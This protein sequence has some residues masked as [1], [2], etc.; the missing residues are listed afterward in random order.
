MDNNLIKEKK[1][2][3]ILIII[4][5]ILGLIVIFSLIF[6][7]E[8]IDTK[9][10]K[11][12]FIQIDNTR[13]ENISSGL[14]NQV[15]LSSMA[16]EKTNISTIIDLELNQITK[17]DQS[18]NNEIETQKVITLNFTTKKMT[19][20]YNQA[21][22]YNDIYIPIEYDLNTNMYTCQNVTDENICSTMKTFTY[23][24]ISEVNNLLDETGLDMDDFNK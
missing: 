11:S 3:K 19:G 8:T 9:L 2:V 15:Y 6:K 10:V 13:Y 16:L 20:Y 21:N 18:L 12:G 14:A 23:N 7:K 17:Y 22:E 4:A 5:I 1:K 24:F